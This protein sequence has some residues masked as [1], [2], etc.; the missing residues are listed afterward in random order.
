[1]TPR[2]EA[3]RG[4]SGKGEGREQK[5]TPRA[6]VP[7][8]RAPLRPQATYISEPA[9]RA[10]A[11]RYER[12][13]VPTPLRSAPLPTAVLPPENEESSAGGAPV[14]LL[15]G[16]DSSALEYRRLHPRLCAAGLEAW[17]VDLLGWGFTGAAEGVQDYS[18]EA[19]RAHLYAFW[20][21]ELGGR[22]MVLCGA[23]LGGAA[24]VDFAVA[25][26]EAVAK[27]VLI[28]AQC[29][30]E[31]A[32]NPPGPLARLG[33]V[34]LKSEP[35]RSMANQMSY[36]DKET[37]A[38][39]DAVRVGRLHC[40]RDGYADAICGFMRSG[41]Y[42]V[43]SRVAQVG[44]ETLILWGNDDGIVERSQAEQ[45][46]ADIAD[47]RLVYIDQCGHVPH[48]EQADKTCEAIVQFAAAAAQ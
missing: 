3:V 40:F 33:V 6:L 35:L 8:T 10:A 13:A 46:K 36:Y 14:V 42:S 12:R 39:E 28:D 5:N 20:Q 9:A 47:S 25:H 7:L 38:T 45:L 41:G 4:A 29:Y 18:P 17:G 23:S 21:E 30:A 19:K 43:A 27:L 37:Y 15:P 1:M 31:D 32:P 16:F 48:L 26:P 44:A 34:V 11:K 22:P 2:G 24:A